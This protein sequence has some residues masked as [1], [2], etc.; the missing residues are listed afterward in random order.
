MGY[1][2]YF[3]Y[4]NSFIYFPD[5]FS[6]RLFLFIQIYFI[7]FVIIEKYRGARR[8]INNMFFYI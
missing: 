5:L 4:I 8:L 3:I 2:F 7:R 6:I 1:D